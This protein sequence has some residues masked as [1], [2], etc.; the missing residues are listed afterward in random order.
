MQL[1]GTFTASRDRQLRLHWDPDECCKLSDLVVPRIT[2]FDAAVHSTLEV[3]LLPLIGGAR[4]L[5][6][7]FGFLYKILRDVNFR[8]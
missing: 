3:L 7:S 1:R 4:F 2:I 8:S 6:P 5:F